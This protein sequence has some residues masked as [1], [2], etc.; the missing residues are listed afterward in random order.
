LVIAGAEVAD[1]RIGFDMVPDVVMVTVAWFELYL[2]PTTAGADACTG[3]DA[4]KAGSDVTVGD[5]VTGAYTASTGGKV[6]GAGVT[7]AV[8]SV[9]K[10]SSGS[11]TAGGATASVIGASTIGSGTLIEAATSGAVVKDSGSTAISVGSITTA[12]GADAGSVT[13]TGSE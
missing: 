6:C 10:A 1:I 7:L 11:T 8:H 9:L 2:C 3:A 13:K 4:G 5:G 12:S